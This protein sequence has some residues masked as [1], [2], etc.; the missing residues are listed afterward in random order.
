MVTRDPRIG[1]SHM[2]IPG[3]DNKYGYGGHCFPKDTKAFLYYSKLKKSKLKL[4]QKAMDL[5]TIH[6]NEK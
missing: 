3:P 2:Q 1:D 5:N 6:R 4:L